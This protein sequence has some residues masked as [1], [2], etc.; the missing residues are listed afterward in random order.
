MS[1]R[2]S[3][4]SI[5]LGWLQYKNNIN[6]FVD[7]IMEI[8]E[9]DLDYRKVK[10]FL[11]NLAYQF[12]IKWK[13]CFRKVH[14]FTVMYDKWLKSEIDFSKYSK[15]LELSTNASENNKKDGNRVSCKTQK[16]RANKVIEKT[17]KST[18]YAATEMMLRNEGKRDSAFIFKKFATGSSKKGTH[19]KNALVRN[20]KPCGLSPDQALAI[21]IDTNL[22]KNQYQILRESVQHINPNLYPSYYKLQ[23]AKERCYPADITIT[24]SSAE[25]NLQSL[26]D[27]TLTRLCLSL[28][29]ELSGISDLCKSNAT[30]NTYKQKFIQIT[31]PT[32]ICLVFQWFLYN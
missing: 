13:K 5:F 27:H 15:S 29:K 1:K 24:E 10:S 26:L 30:Q 7:N 2:L 31:P 12:A 6:E 18:L 11:R 23:K 20:N 14:R 3:V 32:T 17:S 16:R 8:L 4:H 22:S 21:F 28:K 25:I 19:L 9:K